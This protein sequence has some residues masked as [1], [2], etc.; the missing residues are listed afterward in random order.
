MIYSR[1]YCYFYEQING[2]MEFNLLCPRW[3][4]NQTSLLVNSFCYTG[5]CLTLWSTA[6]IQ[7]FICIMDRFESISCFHWRNDFVDRPH[8]WR[9]NDLTAYHCKNNG[10]SFCNRSDDHMT[11]HCNTMIKLFRTY[12]NVI[13]DCSMTSF[14][15][16]TVSELVD[17]RKNRFW[18][19]LN[20]QDNLL[21]TVCQ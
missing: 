4:T 16:A 10:Y 9:L 19:K 8:K 11:D 18:L 6:V 12:D 20:L 7:R 15:L 21:C 17:K 14:G 2:W 5:T 1:F 3:L 13:I